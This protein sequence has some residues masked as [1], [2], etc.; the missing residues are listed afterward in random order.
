MRL[1]TESRLIAARGITKFGDHAWDLA[2]PIMLARIFPG[3]LSE[4]AIYLL[5]NTASTVLFIPK[6]SRWFNYQSRLKNLNLCILSQTVGISTTLLLLYTPDK[7]TSLIFLPAIIFAGILTKIGTTLSDLSLSIDW[8][9]TIFKPQELPAINSKIRRI[10]LLMEVLAPVITG[11][12]L[13]LDWGFELVTLVNLITFILE[14]LLLKII[15]E[16]YDTKLNKLIFSPRPTNNNVKT[17]GF[18][19][20]AAQYAFPII[21]ANACLWYTVLTPHGALLTA[22]LKDS[23]FISEDHLGIIRSAGALIGILPTFY[24]SYVSKRIGIIKFAALSISFQL[25]WLIV[26]VITLENIATIWIAI[27]SI[28][29]S[30][31]GLYGFVLAEL[32][33]RQTTIPEDI[34]LEVS[35]AA[36]ALKHSANLVLYTTAVIWSSPAQFMILAWTTVLV[37]GTGTILTWSR[38]LVT[39]KANL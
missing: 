25:I 31:V 39:H 34:R 7:N 8:I 17:H 35:G 26:S 18:K 30:R 23:A 22:Y 2:I 36:S 12:I 9:P 1:S 29:V 15:Y 32:E 14:F 16:Q 6:L 24:Y 4:V 13:L 11:F 19:I 21:L 38:T 27:A 28:I 33:I 3:S 37:I 20:M 10:D 5:I